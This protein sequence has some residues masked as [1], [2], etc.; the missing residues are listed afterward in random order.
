MEF[1]SRIKFI[2]LTNEERFQVEDISV[3]TGPKIITD[4]ADRAIVSRIKQ[5]N[6]TD[7]ERFF[8][9]LQV[10]LSQAEIN[11][12]LGRRQAVEEFEVQLSKGDWAETDWQ[13]YFERQSWVFGYGL[14][15]LVSSIKCNG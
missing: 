3:T 10:E 12:L 8:R 1:L 2:D 7:R 15:Y 14:D 5:L 13:D 4:A 11:L 9:G 6:H